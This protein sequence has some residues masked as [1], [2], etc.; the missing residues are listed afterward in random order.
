MR[1]GD[2][3]AIVPNSGVIW[4]GEDITH[5]NIDQTIIRSGINITETPPACGESVDN[6]CRVALNLKV[7]GIE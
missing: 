3:D 4:D 1:I 6:P 2:W 7:V 5:W